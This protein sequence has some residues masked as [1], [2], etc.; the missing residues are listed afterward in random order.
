M[1]QAAGQANVHAWPCGLGE[2]CIPKR[3]VQKQKAGQT[4]T[5]RRFGMHVSHA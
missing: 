5:N 2:A 4:L 1:V 3:F